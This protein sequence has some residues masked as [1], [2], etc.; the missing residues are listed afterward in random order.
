MKFIPISLVKPSISFRKKNFEMCNRILKIK[1]FYKQRKVEK[2]FRK[3]DDEI[4]ENTSRSNEDLPSIDDILKDPSEYR[5]LLPVK[6]SN[7]NAWE[8]LMKIE[9][10]PS[11][12]QNIGSEKS[13][14]KQ[15]GV[16]GK[17]M[18]KK[19][20]L[21]IHLRKHTDDIRFVCRLCGYSCHFKG[22]L[23]TH[24]FTHRVKTPRAEHKCLDCGEIFT[25]ILVSFWFF[26]C[27]L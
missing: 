26:L 7:D 9:E 22:N 10:S 19:S 3:A 23:K 16:C 13:N 11:K 8:V 6:G 2:N 5:K 14:P 4:V 24:L 21:R 18:Q 12:I 27:F 15:C 1:E 25:N 20:S 17:I